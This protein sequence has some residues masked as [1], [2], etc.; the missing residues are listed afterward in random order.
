[1]AN[2][3]MYKIKVKGSRQA[4]Y[5]FINMMPSYS[6]EKE[7]LDESGTDEDYELILRGDCKW[8]VSAYTSP[9]ENPQPFTQEELDAVQDG[10]HW[11]KTL[12]DKSVLLDCEIFCNSK[13]IDDSSWAIY[14]HY[15]RGAVMRDECPKLLHIKRGRD[16]DDGGDIVIPLSTVTGNNQCG[17]LCRVKLQGGTYWYVGDYDINDIVSVDGAKKGLFGIVVEIAKNQNTFGYL[18]ILDKRGYLVPFHED[19]VEAIWKSYK[20]VARKEYLAK[21]GFEPEITK[22]KFLTLMFWKWVEYCVQDND[23]NKFIE[24]YK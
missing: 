1:M 11:D 13:D 3:C 8:G 16:Y 6:Y 18:N 23:W 2:I 17:T 10:D 15:N 14:E 20:P 7:I 21:I 19:E 4:C 24:S 22:K 9:M 12:K 5:A